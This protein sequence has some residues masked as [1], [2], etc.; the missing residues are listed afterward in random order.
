[1]SQDPAQRLDIL[2]KVGGEAGH[3]HSEIQQGLDVAPGPFLSIKLYWN[4]VMFVCHGLT[5]TE[6]CVIV[7]HVTCVLILRVQ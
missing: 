6:L 3:T 2:T 5:M 1:M 4:T 7:D